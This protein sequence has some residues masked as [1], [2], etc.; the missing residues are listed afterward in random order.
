MKKIKENPKNINKSIKVKLQNIIKI[1]QVN[2]ILSIYMKRILNKNL[3][4]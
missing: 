3:L 4:I 1:K 2:N